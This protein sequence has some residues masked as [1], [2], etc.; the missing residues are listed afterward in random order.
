MLGAFGLILIA[1]ITLL[2]LQ[3]L[4]I[5]KLDK[6]ITSWLA[7]AVIGEVLFGMGLVYKHFFA[8][9]SKSE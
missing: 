1:T 6:E 5:S 7:T 3:A 8:S 4:G 9:N 2:I